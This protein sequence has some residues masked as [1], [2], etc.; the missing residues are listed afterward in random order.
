MAA[1]ELKRP[2]MAKPAADN[3]DKNTRLTNVRVNRNKTT[4]ESPKT[5]RLTTAEKKMCSD[6]T[7][8]V[9]ELTTKNI[10]DSTVLRAALYLANQAGPEKLLKM[11][12]EHL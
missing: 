9:Q 11:I 5:L 7:E 8:A 2:V 6:L 12:K 10:T 3:P 4:N 1:K